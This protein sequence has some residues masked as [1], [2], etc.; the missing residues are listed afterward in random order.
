[1]SSSEQRERRPDLAIKDDGD[2]V[3]RDAGGLPN[4]K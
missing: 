3:P 1:M 4:F 2:G